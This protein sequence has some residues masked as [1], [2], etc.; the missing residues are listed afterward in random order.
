MLVYVNSI[1]KYQN[2]EALSLKLNSK[3][4]NSTKRRQVN[5]GSSSLKSTSSE[6]FENGVV[7]SNIDTTEIEIEY[8]K[9]T[10]LYEWLGARLNERKTELT[11]SLGQMKSYLTDL[12]A[13]DNRLSQLE[14]DLNTQYTSPPSK[15]FP[16][17]RNSLESVRDDFKR[18]DADLTRL[19]ADLEVIRVKGRPIMLDESKSGASEVKRQLNSLS[20]RF[21]KLNSQNELV[22]VKLDKFAGALGSFESSYGNLGHSLAQKQE[23]L[24]VM[25]AE[26]VNL[27]SDLALIE[28]QLKQMELM[29]SDLNKSDSP[30]LSQVNQNGELLFALAR[31]D[32]DHE[33]LNTQLTKINTDFN[34]LSNQLNSVIEFKQNMQTLSAEL[35]T[36][37]ASFNDSLGK[38]DAECAQLSRQHPS[39]ITQSDVN[40]LECE[41]LPGCV[42]KLEECERLVNQMVDLNRGFHVLNGYT[43]ADSGDDE[44]SLKLSQMRS[45]LASTEARVDQLKSQVNQQRTIDQLHAVLREFIDLKLEQLELDKSVSAS[46]PRLDAQRRAH[47]Q[48][49]GDLIERGDD[50]KKLMEYFAET[51]DVETGA[52]L[53]NKWNQ[54]CARSDARKEKLFICYTMSEQFDKVYEDSKT[55]LTEFDSHHHSTDMTH[56]GEGIEERIGRLKQALDELDRASET[57]MARLNKIG[58]EMKQACTSDTDEIDTRLA[59]IAS[60]VAGV[61]A[62]LTANLEAYNEYLSREKAFTASVSDVK[63]ELNDLES[64]LLDSSDSLASLM[65]PAETRRRDEL[66]QKLDLCKQLIENER[67]VLGDENKS[68][69]L[70][71]LKGLFD[72]LENLIE[73]KQQE[74]IAKQNEEFENFKKELGSLDEKLRSIQEVI[75]KGGQEQQQPAPTPVAKRPI[76]SALQS[77]ND[78]LETANAHLNKYL[79]DERTRCT[80][81]AEQYLKQLQETVKNLTEKC[82]NLNAMQEK[83]E[84]EEKRLFD[85]L[86]A[87]IDTC[88]TAVQKCSGEFEQRFGKQPTSVG[89]NSSS[90]LVNTLIN[91]QQ[92][93]EREHMQPVKNGLEALSKQY[94]QACFGHIMD[95]ER[96]TTLEV[97]YEKLSASFGKLEQKVADR[98]KA[99]DLAMFKSAKFEDK[100]N[101]LDEN[102][103]QVEE[104]L[105]S[106]ERK[107]V[108]FGNLDEIERYID[109]CESAGRQLA[110]TSNEIDEFK[111]ICEK[112]METCESAQ[113]RDTVEKRMDSTVLRWT[114]LN[115]RADE[116]RIN[117][118]YL[119]RH[120]SELNGQYLTSAQFLAGL[121]LK[122]ITELSLN[123]IDPIVIKHQYERMREISDSMAANGHLFRSLRANSNALLAVYDSFESRLNTV[124]GGDD[125]NDTE[126]DELSMNR[127]VSLLPKT[128]SSPCVKNLSEMIDH[129]DV[130]QKVSEVESTFNK[131][132]ELLRGNVNLVERLFPLCEGFSS[133]ISQMSQLIAKHEFELEWLTESSENETSAK[134]KETL[135]EELKRSVKDS[136]EILT[137]L[138]GPLSTSIIDEINNT[139][140]SDGGA[141]QCGELILDLNENIDRVKLKFG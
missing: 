71:E 104:K 135:Y 27:N 64:R 49:I 108:G 123:C 112:I 53:E 128:I 127:Y 38:I 40:A 99:L 65:D 37:R 12:H 10:E 14:T 42:R 32:D 136:E 1:G 45:S 137:S 59:E 61:R 46:L 96:L 113:E 63:E 6:N 81:S 22:K 29:R 79:V 106:L 92:Q 56:T 18:I 124:N 93:F 36:Q 87:E 20:D 111:E 54:L 3:R 58:G 17:D 102:L 68:R 34:L 41:Q 125:D 50:V 117:L 23:M 25:A 116:M 140:T 44:L 47:D 8:R 85:E 103:R 16:L 21:T 97:K 4:G 95:A 72:R 118:N 107:K 115:K 75:M 89:T 110:V 7:S 73:A 130:E 26:K 15:L 109:E 39:S 131:Y 100:I 120:L 76:K 83:E 138:E 94:E 129:V 13:I 126:D 105:S 77:V 60:R 78:E 122:Y 90:V 88:N 48:F 121:N 43:S 52:N 119:A 31:A 80:P 28:V 11:N 101:I 139:A 30:L 55:Y 57:E 74:Q 132:A 66:R 33:R 84:S 70:N 69:T 19:G 62:K 82:E 91:E 141:N 9:L 67:S 5:G 51:E 98:S 134:E 2:Q 133:S 114:L 86:L 24:D 35:S